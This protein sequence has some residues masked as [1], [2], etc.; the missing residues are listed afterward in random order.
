[1]GRDFRGLAAHQPLTQ[2]RRAADFFRGRRRS[3][4]ARE[5]EPGGGHRL[6]EVRGRPGH[7]NCGAG[8]RLHAPLRG[9]LY[10][11]P[12]GESETRHAAHGSVP[13]G[14]VA[15]AGDASGAQGGGDQ[16][17]IGAVRAV[18]LDRDG[19]LNEV[20]VREGLP[21]PPARPEEL[22]LAPGAAEALARLKAAGFLLI[23]V[24]NQPDVA[25]GR[26]SRAA[27]EAMNRSVIA[28]LPLDGLRVCWHDDGDACTCRKP[29]PG[30]LLDAAGDYGIDLSRSFL[31]GDR[32]RDIEAGAAAGCRTVLIDRQYAERPPVTPPD[33]RADSLTAAVEWIL[34]SS[35]QRLGL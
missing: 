4:K 21:Y 19:V 33:F 27:A 30:L 29:K 31:I 18:F 9:R 24:T 32:W 17:G 3:G 11:G 35:G 25:R 22:R 10:R 28:A 14:L 16:V 12:R 7:W 1:M 34:Q 26:Q 15:P 23:V 5:P 13:G 20:V 2:R 6:C 8:W